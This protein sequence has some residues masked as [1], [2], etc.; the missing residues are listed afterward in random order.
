MA[1]LVSGEIAPG[2]GEQERERAPFKLTESGRRDSDPAAWLRPLPPVLWRRLSEEA[3]EA[4]ER[5]AHGHAQAVAR[6]QEL[7]DKLRETEAADERALRDALRSGARPPKPKRQQAEQQAEQAQR[8]QRVAAQLVIE[9]GGELVR[10]FSDEQMMEAVAEAERAAREAIARVPTLVD[11]VLGALRGLR[12]RRAHL[13]PRRAGRSADPG[14]HPSSRVLA[15]PGRADRRRRG[16]ARAALG[17][18]AHAPGRGRRLSSAGTTDGRRCPGQDR[19]PVSRTQVPAP[20]CAAASISRDGL[21]L[22]TRRSRVRIPP[23]LPLE[24]PAKPGVSTFT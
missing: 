13:V 3:R 18:A 1:N 11:E 20:S 17:V 22:M 15:D 6:A 5:L 23:P 24:T 9:S 14:L 2:G 10:R 8:E 7:A 12:I 21:A 19:G 16:R 4:H